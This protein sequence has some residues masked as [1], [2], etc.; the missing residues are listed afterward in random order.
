M[1]GGLVPIT[2]EGWARGRGYS[3]GMT[4]PGGSRLVFVAGQ[5]AWDE[6]QHL[7]GAGD[8]PTQFG[9]ALANVMT[10]VR[11]AGGRPEDVASMTV[12]VTDL[13]AYRGAAKTL[14]EIW[15]TH[16]G[17]H[18]PAMALVGVA[19]LVAPGAMVEI[20]AVAAI[21]AAE[22]RGKSA[23]AAALRA[24]LTEVTPTLAALP[25]VEMPPA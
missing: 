22:K 12:Y 18:Y 21:A 13:D 1:S 2:P 3:N 24:S 16:M 7:V 8:L 19:G 15:Q 25:P 20:Q 9:K 11:T 4:V 23:I 17:K 5:I 14:G 10:V 6:G